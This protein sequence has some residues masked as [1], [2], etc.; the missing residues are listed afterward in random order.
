MHLDISGNRLSDASIRFF[1]EVLGKFSGFRSV[2]LRNVNQIA[3]RNNTGY[4]ELAKA[5]RENTSLIELDLRH[6][7]ITD[8]Q[9]SRILQ[10]L[11]ENFVLSDLRLEMK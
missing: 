4:I 1:A 7:G 10:A 9:T 3:T 5:L 11:T 6:N 2:N 8:E